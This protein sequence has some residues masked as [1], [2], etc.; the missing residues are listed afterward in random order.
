MFL[1]ISRPKQLKTG[2]NSPAEVPAT[3][4]LLGDIFRGVNG[5]AVSQQLK[6][7]MWTG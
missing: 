6:M 2:E 7:D 5:F 3:A 4:D 1:Q